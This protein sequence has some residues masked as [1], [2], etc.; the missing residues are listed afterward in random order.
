[1]SSDNPWKAYPGYRVYPPKLNM[2]TE[3]VDRHVRDRRGQAPAVIWAEGRWSFA[4]L[5]RVVNAF[6]ATAKPRGL[7]KVARMMV[8]GRNT[9]QGVAAVLA[10][11]KIGAVP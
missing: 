1:M 6:A 5:Q 3:I 11:L 4:D 9:P 7:G 10:G 8:L 2:C